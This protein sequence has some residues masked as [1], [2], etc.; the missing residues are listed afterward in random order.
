[1][2][3]SFAGL[4][5]ERPKKPDSD[6]SPD[7]FSKLNTEM[8]KTSINLVMSRWF[9]LLGLV[10]YSS[11]FIAP[12]W[13]AAKYFAEVEGKGPQKWSP[14]H[15]ANDFMELLLFDMQL[16]A[17]GTISGVN[18]MSQYHSRELGEA[19]NAVSRL[20]LHH[21]TEDLV[22]YSEKQL[23]LMN[24]VVNVYPAAIR[25]IEPEYG[26]HFDDGGYI[27][28]AETD[29]FEL[30]QV[31]P[32]KKGVEVNQ[33]GKPTLIIPPYILGANILALLPG[34]DR[35][36]AHAFANHGIPTYVRIVKDI[37]KTPAV[38]VMTGEDDA[39]DT[40]SFAEKIAQ[41]HGKPVTL[42]GYCQGGFM[43]VID[44]LSGELD[45]LVD[46]LIT[47]VAPMDGSRSKSLMEYIDHLP[48]RFM[49]LGYS[50]KT[51]PNGNKVVDGKVIGW[52]FKL[53]SVERESPMSNF[54]R[55]LAMFDRVVEGSSAKI[56]KAAAAISHWLT[57]DGTDLPVEITRLSYESYTKPV[58]TDGTM[59]MKL[60]G[61]PLNFRRLKEKGIRW[62]LC[63]AENDD[64]IDGESALAALDH[65]D[66]EVVVF[67]KGHAAI[68]TSWSY[69]ASEC[70][71][72]ISFDNTMC[73]NG[74]SRGPVRFQL[75]LDKEME[76]DSE[77]ESIG[78]GSIKENG[79]L[80]ST[81]D[82]SLRN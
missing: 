77:S 72:D 69:P 25:D 64:L 50:L 34:E 14:W 37:Q 9:H 52:I 65:V 6:F 53:K 33:T 45:G 56:S 12:Y 76:E 55:D 7:G 82:E 41:R 20:L 81:E 3:Y 38:Q 74:Q 23:K 67:P 19:L 58:S 36:Y 44:L 42:N 80:G 47:C 68:A 70:P 39:R 28:V 78:V 27:K 59:P 18:A 62:L 21:D 75:D 24:T 5:P 30:Y 32:V 57:Y 11:N 66:A 48:H 35:S 46:A 79:Q 1:M 71:L 43:S 73:S 31:L 22:G 51:L 54:Y 26:F 40:R 60:F 61:R 4:N 8:L 17:K 10:E 16:A 2:I 63:I 49:D 13:N 15:A 29:R